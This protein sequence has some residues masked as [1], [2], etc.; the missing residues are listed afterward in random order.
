MVEQVCS[1]L[2]V[3]D[4]ALT[5]YPGFHKCLAISIYQEVCILHGAWPFLM[6]GHVWPYIA[7]YGRLN[8][9]KRLINGITRLI[10]GL[11]RLINGLGAR[12][13][14]EA[15]APPEPTHKAMN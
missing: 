15:A 4:E 14:P 3:W 12:Q 9:I 5:H 11:T 7:I 8:V 10:K 6:Y 2:G 1:L 13:G